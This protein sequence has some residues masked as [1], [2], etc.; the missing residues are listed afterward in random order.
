[1]KNDLY[2]HHFVVGKIPLAF[3]CYIT[4]HVSLYRVTG[5]S[6]DPPSASNF[7]LQINEGDEIIYDTLASNMSLHVSSTFKVSNVG[8]MNK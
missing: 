7:L 3:Q 2:I 4:R 5:I 1:M 6:T 8:C